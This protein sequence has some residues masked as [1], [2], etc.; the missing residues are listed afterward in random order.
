MKQSGRETV[1]V[2]DDDD[3]EDETKKSKIHT[4]LDQALA[5]A[6]TQN[7]SES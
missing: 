2:L 6:F 5:A 1:A 4:T 3:E 7:S